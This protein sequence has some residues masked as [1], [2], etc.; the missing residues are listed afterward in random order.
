MRVAPN[1]LQP[2]RTGMYDQLA[3]LPKR[4]FVAGLAKQARF[5]VAAGSNALAALHWEARAV[6][7]RSPGQS[8]CGASFDARVTECDDSQHVRPR[9][10]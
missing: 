4:D 9:P 3:G 2:G 6:D 5:L 8:N 7:M 10:G 1:L